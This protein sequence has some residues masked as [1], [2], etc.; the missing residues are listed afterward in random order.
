MDATLS[1]P[2]PARLLTHNQERRIHH[3][4]RHSIVKQWRRAGKVWAH[5]CKTPRF[6]TVEIV[7]QVEQAKGTLADP[8]AHTPVIKAIVDGLV[9]AKVL[10]DDTGDYVLGITN[11]PVI[12]GD[13]DKVTLELHGTEREPE[14]A[15]VTA[16]TVMED[17]RERRKASIARQQKA[18]PHPK[19]HRVLQVCTDCGAS[20]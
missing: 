17:Y 5:V 8:Q 4:E 15:E 18:C 16:S 13:L 19:T 10:I 1:I 14:L 12:R 11:L 7:V 2:A 9:D 6:Q 20:C 3:M